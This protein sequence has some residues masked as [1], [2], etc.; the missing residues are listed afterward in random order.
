M[1]SENIANL[2][3]IGANE[4]DLKVISAYLQDSIVVVRDIVFL[5][6]NKSFVM[7]VNRFMWEDVEKGILR[8]N[9][10]V[11]S[12][13]RFEGVIEVKSKNINQKNPN[14]ILE[15]LAMRCDLDK[16]GNKK[17]K[18]FFSGNSVIV[19]ILE[20]I[21]VVMNDLGKPWSVKFVPIHEI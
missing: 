3:L 15:F 14:K 5:K 18:I 8:S 19:L 2:N 21:D 20:D 16:K 1:N 13:V 4:E 10:R 9:K 7:I 11:R 17:I 6:K 12:A